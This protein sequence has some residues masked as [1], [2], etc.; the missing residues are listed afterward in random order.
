MKFVV[1][2]H[3][4]ERFKE[5]LGLEGSELR[6]AL[7]KNLQDC[8]VYKQFESTKLIECQDF[9][10]GI[11]VG[12]DGCWVIQTVM[13]DTPFYVTRLNRKPK[14]QSFNP[15]IEISGLN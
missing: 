7:K 1:S 2:Y 12:N 10:L 9:V 8:G 4:Q 6:T 13:Y 11:G 14:I 3:A 5:R 15:Q